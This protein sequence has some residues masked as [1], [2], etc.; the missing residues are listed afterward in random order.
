MSLNVYKN[1]DFS[2]IQ[3]MYKCEI[4]KFSFEVI[5]SIYRE[6][7]DDTKMQIHFGNYPKLLILGP[8][9]YGYITINHSNGITV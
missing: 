7:L 2:E 9:L 5:Y 8:M 4:S 1:T 3:E 6:V